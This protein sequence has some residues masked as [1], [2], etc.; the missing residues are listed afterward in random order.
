MSLAKISSGDGYEYYLRNTVTNDANSRGRQKMEDYYSER[1]ETPGRWLGSGLAALGI[2]EGEEVTEAQMRALI[3]FGRHPNARQ[4]KAQLISEQVGLGAKR[5]HAVRY[6]EQ[7]VKLGRAFPRFT[8]AGPESYRG[9]V[10]AAF[11]EWNLAHDRPE[12]AAIPERT[13]REIR[14]QVATRMFTDEHDRAPLDSHELS[15]WTARASRPTRTAVAAWDLTFSP[16]KSVSALWALSP[17]PIADTIAAAHHAAVRDTMA[18]LEKHAA[19]ARAG[20]HSVRQVDVEGLICLTFDHR[21]SRAGDPDLHTHVVVS[22]K[23]RRLTGEWGALDGRILYREAVTASELYNSRLEHHLEAALGIQFAQRPGRDMHKRPI[24]EVVGVDERLLAQWSTRAEDITRRLGQLAGTFQSTHGR[25]PNPKELLDLGEEATLSTRRGKHAPRSYAEQRA[26]WRAEAARVLGGEQAITSMVTGALSQQIPVREAITEEW[27]TA[28]AAVAVDTVAAGRATWKANHV[29]AEIVR[30]LR[31]RVSPAEH[32]RILDRALTVALSPPMS[33]AYGGR[34][35]E[36]AIGVLARRDGTSVYSTSGA[37]MYTSAA[38]VAAEQSLLEAAVLTGGRTIPVTATRTAAVEFA[39]NHGGIGLTSEQ[40]ALVE[41]FATSGLR[42]QLGI[43]PAGTGKTTTMQVLTNAWISEGGT[44]LG[45]APTGSA[46]GKLREDTSIETLTVDKLLSVVDRLDDGRLDPADAPAW[47]HAID[48]RTLVV[49]DEAAKCGTLQ[50]DRAVQWLLQRGASI[51]AIGD[52]RQLSSVAAGGVVRDIVERAGALSLTRV[53]RFSDP[54]EPAA[55]LALREGDSA[56]IAYYTDNGRV[57]V[58]Q[59]GAVVEAAFQAWAADTATGLD[60]LLLAPTRDLVGTLNE[61][62]RDA[63]RAS[64]PAEGPEVVLADGL[65]AA[66]GDV[67]C[68]RRNDYQR[69]ISATD[70]VRNG[71]RWRVQQVHR[72]G[73]ITASHLTSGRRVTLDSEYVRTQVTLGFASTI[74]TAQGLTADTCHGIL[75]GREHRAQ[76]YVM[77]TRGRGG[78][79]AYISTAGSGHDTNPRTHEKTHPATAV[80]LFSAIL[81]R[82]GTQTS[83]TSLD[84]AGTDPRALLSGLVDAYVDAVGLVAEHRVGADRLAE[85]TTAAE[86]LVPGLSDEHAWPVLRQHLATL[87]VNGRDPIAELDAAVH[88]R[89]LDTADDR[90]AVLDWRIDPTTGHSRGRGEYTGPLGWMPELP[91]ALAADPEYGQV[92]QARS[93]ALTGPVMQIRQLTQNWTIDTAPPWAHPFLENHALL[94]DLTVFRAALNVPDTDRRPTGPTLYPV[95]ERRIQRS[96]EDQATKYLG[97]L[98]GPARRWAYLA[99]QLDVHLTADPYWPIL[100]DKLDTAHR[101]GL[102]IIGAVRDAV[103]AR[104]LPAEQ[105]AAAL[106]WRLTSTLDHHD[107][108]DRHEFAAALSRAD[109]DRWMGMSDDQLDARARRLVEDLD[110]S[111]WMY[112]PLVWEKQRERAEHGSHV[113]RAHTAHAQL[114]EQADAITDARQALADA[115]QAAINAHAARQ[116]SRRAG[117][118]TPDI[119]WWRPVGRET[120]QIRQDHAQHL[121]DLRQAALDA[122]RDAAELARIARDK[123]RDTVLIAGIEERWDDIQARATDPDAFADQLTQAEERDQADTDVLARYDQQRA[124]QQNE[125]DEITAEQQRRDDLTPEGH[126]LEERAR[127]HRLG[128]PE[129]PRKRA[130]SHSL[131][132]TE[133]HYT[134]APHVGYEGPGI[135]M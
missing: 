6:A 63:R 121:E 101:A 76:A 103:S 105:P 114:L 5:V 30:Q 86:Q 12:D 22:A 1:G 94:H 51:R 34:E 45:L 109:H 102:D 41:A 71:Y 48:D 68:T 117:E 83:A 118:T 53:M 28:V 97:D 125:L 40:A 62:A 21:D 10:S 2:G 72:D 85:I 27:I 66:A 56:A 42:L 49:L 32:D 73:R 113:D 3:G 46:A 60:A 35:I 106:R 104:P 47:L 128:P 18:Y 61:R 115:Q 90:A 38:V 78:N 134:P 75:T 7:A 44:V 88:A 64:R 59:L 110:R 15:A 93:R 98:R 87:A 107:T 43:A 13:R 130:P 26:T 79:F 16:V 57:Q 119:P 11:A 37:T 91:S 25:E 108:T 24:R 129:E 112:N 123:V 52:D 80:D 39:A 82:E 17:K 29:R 92:L 9:Q 55:S 84:R 120:Q 89:E 14:T 74:D 100:A 96:L 36:P 70:C 111:P 54:A 95:A 116:A 65:S 81:G 124:D 127:Q 20:R 77:L 69:R 19:F 50:L 4:I 99:R 8:P 133:P 122:E 126:A 135:G 31:G 132:P 33:I 23:V 58:G 67:I 131:E